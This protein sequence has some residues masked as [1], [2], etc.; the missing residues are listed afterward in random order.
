MA[1]TKIAEGMHA[2]TIKLLLLLCAYCCCCCF[3]SYICV[4]NC[5]GLDI[6]YFEL[7]W[8]PIS[9]AAHS[10]RARKKTPICTQKERTSDFCEKKIRL[11]FDF[12][13]NRNLRI[14]IVYVEL[15][16]HVVRTWELCTIVFITFHC[17]ANDAQFKGIQRWE[18]IFP[19]F[20]NGF[21]FLHIFSAKKEQINTLY[22]IRDKDDTCFLLSPKISL[23]YCVAQMVL[24][25]FVIKLKTVEEKLR[26]LSMEGPVN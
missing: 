13:H 3:R 7:R 25:I 11:T 21:I 4:I 9:Y 10:K 17:I 14:S 16:L 12:A 5:D 19:L 26:S 2:C 22:H 15:V 20:R 18:L 1:E 8:K 23:C 24:K 6:F